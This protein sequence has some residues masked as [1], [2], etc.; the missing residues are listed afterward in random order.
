MMKNNNVELVIGEVTQADWE[1]YEIDSDLLTP[2][3]AWRVTMGFSGDKKIPKCVEL[4]AGVKVKVGGETVLVGYLDTIEHSVSKTQHTLSLSGRDMASDLLDCSCPLFDRQMVSLTEIIIIITREFNIK[5]HR[6]DA[7]PS[8]VRKKIHVNP[9]ESA[10]SVLSDAAEA[11]GL[12]PWFESDGTLV[13]GGPDYSAPVVASLILRR[14]G[15]GNNVLSLNYS[16]D[17]QGKYSKITV[18][19]QSHGDFINTGKNDYHGEAVDVG[20]IR[21]RP[22]IINEGG[23]ENS[24]ICRN[25]ARKLIADGRLHGLTLS[26]CVVGHHIVAPGQPSDGILWRAGQRVH[27]VSDPHNID[28]V[29]FV[30]ARKF[31]RSRFDGTRTTL[32]LKEDGVWCLDAHLN[33]NRNAHTKNTGAGQIIDVAKI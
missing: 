28:A 29:F 3:D 6:V 12:F 18:L 5:R 19:G 14:S 31:T 1:S 8:L 13:V 17:M 15:K 4:G 16:G 27:V 22:K 32:T 30:M 26:V 20:V 10:W 23:C 33:K 25:R 2:A 7:D 21:H 9:G 24:A 11:N